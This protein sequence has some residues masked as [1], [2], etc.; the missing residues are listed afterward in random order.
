MQKKPNHKYILEAVFTR[1]TKSE[2][3]RIL[4]TSRQYVSSW[5]RVPLVHAKTV[6]RVT[7]IPLKILRPDVYD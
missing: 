1:I 4:K 2:M 5:K 7:E 6:S 3:S